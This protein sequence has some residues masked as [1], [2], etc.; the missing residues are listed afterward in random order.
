VGRVP[1][2]RDLVLRLSPP[3]RRGRVG[4]APPHDRMRRPG[5]GAAEAARR[6]R[7]TALRHRAGDDGRGANR[8][9]RA[10][11][12]ALVDAAATRY[13][14]SCPASRMI[15]LPRRRRRS[16]ATVPMTP[17]RSPDLMNAYS[18]C[19]ASRRSTFTVGRGPGTTTRYWCGRRDHDESHDEWQYA[20]QPT[21]KTRGGIHRH[22]MLAHGVTARALREGR[23]PGR[24]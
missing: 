16:L 2:R 17:I 14:A 22:R 24:A 4:R 9:V 10:G 8:E 21:A 7:A 6:E 20:S 5:E 15:D 23:R 13:G 12:P 19:G 1:G 11:D 18:L 3:R